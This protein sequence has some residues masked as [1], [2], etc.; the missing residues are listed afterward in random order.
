MARLCSAQTQARR[1]LCDCLP[2]PH[3]HP[4]GLI[5]NHP[6]IFLTWSLSTSSPHFLTPSPPP[7]GS[8]KP[9]CDASFFQKQASEICPKLE[10]CGH[11]RILEQGELLWHR[12]FGTG[13][14]PTKP[15]LHH[16]EIPPDAR[17]D[18]GTSMSRSQGCQT[19]T[20]RKYQNHKTGF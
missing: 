14:C 3:D 16:S 10:L 7:L 12:P 5:L 8:A 18:D 11:L 6:G 20:P 15:T 1:S 4:A 2:N 13:C 19:Q 17:D 9:N